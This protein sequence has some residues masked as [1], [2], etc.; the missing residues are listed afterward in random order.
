MRSIGGRPLVV[1]TSTVEFEYLKRLRLV[2]RVRCKTRLTYLLT[3]V[4]ADRS[5]WLRRD[6]NM[7][8]RDEWAKVLLEDFKREIIAAH[9]AIS[10]NNNSLSHAAFSSASPTVHVSVKLVE[11]WVKFEF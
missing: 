3:C 2:C 7:I 8:G 10:S 5:H 11:I 9:E 6:E 4:G 1:T